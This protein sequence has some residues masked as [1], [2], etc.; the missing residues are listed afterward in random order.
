MHERRK[1]RLLSQIKFTLKFFYISL[2]YVLILMV[3][4]FYATWSIVK[5]LESAFPYSSSWQVDFLVAQACLFLSILILLATIMIIVHRAMGPVPRIEAILDAVIKG[6]YTQRI[7]LRRRDFLLSL[8]D[9]LN[10]VLE[11]LEQKK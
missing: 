1:T 11:L 6:D 7:H 2:T 4:N 5:E 8:A 9:K 10:K 3:I